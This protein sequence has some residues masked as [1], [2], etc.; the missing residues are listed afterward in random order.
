MENNNMNFLPQLCGHQGLT[1]LAALG[2]I[3]LGTLC[4]FSVLYTTYFSVIFLGI[5]LIVSS[6]I[7][8][9]HIFR[10]P[11]HPSFYLYL[12]SAILSL[13]AGAVTLWQPTLSIM[14]LTLLI[15]SM[16]L[17]TGVFKTISGFSLQ[18][19]NRIWVILNGILS[20]ILGGLVMYQWPQSSLWFIGLYVAIDIMFS[21][22]TLLAL[23]LQLPHL[24]N[25]EP[26]K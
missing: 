10:T 13:V 16:L 12:I 15:A 2:L 4:L 24:C 11:N 9:V 20:I 18:S 1:L 25:T 7:Q 14:S 23:A 22:W 17:V 6:I 21:G 19:N 5:A 8:I 26:K 3:L